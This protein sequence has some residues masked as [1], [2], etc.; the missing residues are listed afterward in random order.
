MKKG[1]DRL[2]SFPARHFLKNDISLIEGS[3]FRFSRHYSFLS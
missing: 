1:N 2:K 3:V